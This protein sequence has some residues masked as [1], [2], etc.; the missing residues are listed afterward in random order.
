MQVDRH[1]SASETLK[2][3]PKKVMTVPLEPWCPA[4]RVANP[5]ARTCFTVNSKPNDFD[6]FETDCDDEPSSRS[7]KRKRTSTRKPL[8]SERPGWRL[9]QAYTK[10][11]DASGAIKVGRVQL[12]SHSNV[13][14]SLPGISLRRQWGPNEKSTVIGVTKKPVQLGKPLSFTILKDDTPI[15]IDTN[16][17]IGGKLSDDCVALL[18]LDAIDMLGID[19]NHAV[20]NNRHVWIKYQIP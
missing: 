10:Y 3:G 11:R 5:I 17:P 2:G 4:T 7:R 1:P 9:L 15:V 16:R 13:N 8:S 14:Y 20:R 12:D 6:P 19:L 18:G